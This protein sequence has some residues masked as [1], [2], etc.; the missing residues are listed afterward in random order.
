MAL[1][2][3]KTP[4]GLFEKIKTD[5]FAWTPEGAQEGANKTG[6]PMSS[7]GKMVVKPIYNPQSQQFEGGKI[8]GGTTKLPKQWNYDPKES[9]RFKIKKFFEEP[10]TK[11]FIKEIYPPEVYEAMYPNEKKK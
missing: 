5:Q 7:L 10:D 2:Q 11:A 1:L 3:A 8:E 6:R 4:D 9:S